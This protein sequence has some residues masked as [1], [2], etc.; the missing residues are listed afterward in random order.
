MA[1][2]TE[3]TAEK[4]LLLIMVEYAGGELRSCSGPG[5]VEEE[6]DE[7]KNF[8]IAASSLSS[9]A[10]RTLLDFLAPSEELDVLAIVSVALST[11]I[12]CASNASGD[13]FL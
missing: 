5:A 2:S 4:G 6:E 10:Y 11:L 13:T 1:E 12:T 8:L 3:V 9:F 7:E